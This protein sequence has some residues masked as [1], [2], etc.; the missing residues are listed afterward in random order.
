MSKSILAVTEDQADTLTEIIRDH[1]RMM[2][3]ASHGY[4]SRVSSIES[5]LYMTLQTLHRQNSPVWAAPMKPVADSEGWWVVEIVGENFIEDSTFQ[6]AV[7]LTDPLVPPD[8][9]RDSP[10]ADDDLLFITDPI[11]VDS[12]ADVIRRSIAD[13]PKSPF[14]RSQVEVRMGNPFGP[15]RLPEEQFGGGVRFHDHTLYIGQWSVRARKAGTPPWS[16]QFNA[17]DDPAGK[18]NALHGSQESSEMYGL[19]AAVSQATRSVPDEDQSTWRLVHDVFDLSP[20]FPVPAGS[21][22][23]IQY[24]PARAGWIVGSFMPPDVRKVVH[25]PKEEIDEETGEELDQDLLVRIVSPTDNATVQAGGD[26]PIRVRAYFPDPP[27]VTAAIDGN[28]LPPPTPAEFTFRGQVADGQTVNIRAYG[29]MPGQQPS[30]HRIKV[31]GGQTGSSGTTYDQPPAYQSFIAGEEVVSSG[32]WQM[33][34]ALVFA[35]LTAKLITYDTTRPEPPPRVVGRL[36]MGVFGNWVA[37]WRPP[38]VWQRTPVQGQP[39]PPRRTQDVWEMKLELRDEGGRE[40][41][42]RKYLSVV[43]DDPPTVTLDIERPP[44]APFNPLL[45]LRAY[46]TDKET[47]PCHTEIWYAG[48]IVASGTDQPQLAELDPPPG[49]HVIKVLARDSRGQEAEHFEIVTI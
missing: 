3:A 39:P 9:F 14:T 5:P 42:V 36:Y 29:T 16:V 45:R 6:I 4:P 49:Q 7:Y 34:D 46:G 19:S 35:E 8:N 12:T 38:Q 27:Q 24:D 43:I 37:F 28:P 31:I 40:R 10:W 32:S 13:H 47:N 48:Q 20:D 18:F 23:I 30:E 26:F 44:S 2:P 25:D 21:K 11:P 17:F 41:E 1:R 15:V 22:A 33:P